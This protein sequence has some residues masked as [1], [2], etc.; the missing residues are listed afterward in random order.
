MSN[1]ITTNKVARYNDCNHLTA[2]SEHYFYFGRQKIQDVSKFFRRG[3]TRNSLAHVLFSTQRA[4]LSRLLMSKFSRNRNKL[5]YLH[6]SALEDTEKPVTSAVTFDQL[7]WTSRGITIPE[8]Q[9]HLMKY[10]YNPI[11]HKNSLRFIRAGG[12]IKQVI[13]ILL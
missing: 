10:S 9:H 5:R 4:V 2:D 1:C 6:P 3:Q 7:D 8:V 13:L 12:R 11:P